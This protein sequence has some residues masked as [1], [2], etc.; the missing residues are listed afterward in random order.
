MKRRAGALLGCFVL[1]TCACASGSGAHRAPALAPDGTY[2]EAGDILA[3]LALLRQVPSMNILLGQTPAE[4][5][6]LAESLW[7]KGPEA[8]SPRVVYGKTA[9]KAL[10]P[11]LCKA[12]ADAAIALGEKAFGANDFQA[13]AAHYQKAI[14]V[15][16]ECVAAWTYLG[17]CA[18]QTSLF[19]EALFA[20][21][22]AISLNPADFLPVFFRADALG[23]LGR[24][25]EAR[26]SYI[27]ALVLR[28]GRPSIL[29]NV[30]ALAAELQVRVHDELLAPKAALGRKDGKLAVVATTPDWLM[31]GACKALWR[32]DEDHR[33]K[34]TGRAEDRWTPI[35]EREC[36]TVLLDAHRRMKDHTR[37]RDPQLAELG[38][39]RANVGPDPELDWVAGIFAEGMGGAF[40][41]WEIAARMSPFATLLLSDAEQKEL[42]R[43][44][45]KYIVVSSPGL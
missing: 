31:Y 14:A 10:Q 3:R 34:L 7:P 20:Y 32:I 6:R 40:I 38:P 25:D 24:W 33:K 37:L 13:A 30:R 28:P 45:E 22:H 26:Q 27:H 36:F 16:P 18:F 35:E 8:V 1:A 15:D 29:K 2:L 9:G 4:L 41:T 17:D 5:A 39:I 44:V 43:F 12:E 11:V 23:K 19:Q 42:E 21:D